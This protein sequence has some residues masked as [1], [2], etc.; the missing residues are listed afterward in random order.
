M[1][2]IKKSLIVLIL[3]VP[4]L[5]WIGTSVNASSWG[6]GIVVSDPEYDNNGADIYHTLVGNNRAYIHVSMPRYSVSGTFMTSYATN[7]D[8]EIKFYDPANIWFDKV[9]WNPDTTNYQVFVIE[10]KDNQGT[11]TVDYSNRKDESKMIKIR[12]ASDKIEVIALIDQPLGP[13]LELKLYELSP[14]V[15]YR[16]YW[17]KSQTFNNVIVNDLPDTYGSP[18]K[19]GE[20]GKVTLSLNGSYL[21]AS[22]LY[23][24]TY[25]LA[26][27]LVDN[28]TV[29]QN[30]KKAYYWTD[31]TDK[32]ITM[33]YE[34]K[35]PIYLSS[36]PIAARP[37]TQTVTWNLTTNEVRSLNKVEVF[38]YHT[39]DKDR[40]ISTYM[41]MPNTISDNIISVTAGFSYQYDYHFTGKGEVLSDIVTLTAGSKNTYSPTWEKKILH[42]ILNPGYSSF[43]SGSLFYGAIGID[44][45]SFNPIR[46]SIDQIQTVGYPTAELVN[47]ITKAWNEKYKTNVTI[48]TDNNKLYKLNWGQ[49]D[50]FGAKDV[51]MLPDSFSFAEIVFVKDG[52]VNLLT[53]DDIILKD[54]VGDT[55]LPK[56]DSSLIKLIKDFI[57]KYPEIAIGIAVVLSILFLLVFMSFAPIITVFFQIISGVLRVTFFL[58]TKPAF[59]VIIVIGSALIMIVNNT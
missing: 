34:E 38:A 39:K 14:N 43:I 11:Y 29:F 24:D 17:A 40:V 46:K 27:M 53:F 42:F 2:L 36:L 16:M 7:S 31:G 13:D 15:T 35:D 51:Y 21:H 48:D 5:L 23:Y 56:D 49:Y 25:N 55:L 50:K 30:V 58:M 22:V 28:V 44:I 9:I 8:H 6:T 33:T 41:Y 4:F 32:M 26:P 18:Y 20:Y 45:S 52:K 57:A 59:W 47:S 54:V 1:A 10:S 19:E 3:I 37:W 12:S